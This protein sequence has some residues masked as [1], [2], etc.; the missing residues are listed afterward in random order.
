M[1]GRCDSDAA[2]DGACR[3]EDVV[4]AGEPVRQNNRRSARDVVQTVLV[5]DLD[6]VESEYPDRVRDER[7]CPGLLDRL[8]YLSD[9]ARRYDAER[10]LRAP[11]GLYRDPFIFL[12]SL[13]K[14]YSFEQGFELSGSA[15]VV[16]P[17]EGAC[18]REVDFG[19]I[20]TP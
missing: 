2:E 3:D 19:H 18:G 7:F 10:A 11:M 8:D 6:I 17:S 9:E 16:V 12:E 1:N 13:G 20:K 15:V 5:R 4:V 14:V